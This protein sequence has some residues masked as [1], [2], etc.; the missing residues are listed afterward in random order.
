V[1]NAIGTARDDQDH[2][3]EAPGDVRRRGAV[4]RFGQH[5]QQ[6]PGFGKSLHH[7]AAQGPR[8]GMETSCQPTQLTGGV[9]QHHAERY[10]PRVHHVGN[11]KG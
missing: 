9:N 3:E 2:P 11:P 10:L 5:A 6:E 1:F 7:P 4:G 8:V